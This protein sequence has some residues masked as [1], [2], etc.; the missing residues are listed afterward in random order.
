MSNRKC[1][2]LFC[3]KEYYYLMRNVLLLLDE[4][5]EHRV[6]AYT[7]NFSLPDFFKNVLPQRIDDCNLREYELTGKNDL[8]KNNWDKTMYSCFLKANVICK[9]LETGFDEF[10]YLDVDTFPT[11]NINKVFDKA[12]RNIGYPILPRYKWEIMLFG[13]KGNPYGEGGYKEERTLEWWL[14]K[15]LGIEN[16][17]E[18]SWYRQSCFMYYDI[19]SKPFWEEAFSILSDEEIF[20]NQDEFFGDESIINVLLWKNRMEAH[21]FEDKSAIHIS[22]GD[23]LDSVDKIDAFFK[24]LRSTEAGPELVLNWHDKEQVDHAWLFHGKVSKFFWKENSLSRGRI[25]DEGENKKFNKY[26]VDKIINLTQ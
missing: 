14:I 24:E 6:L 22:N 1:Y 3:D 13:D 10:V 26:F 21:Y 12:K 4:F 7:I 8:I 16:I 5:S 20:K 11:A 2:V 19:S 18:R 25:Y 9:S 17:F 23:Q 15:K